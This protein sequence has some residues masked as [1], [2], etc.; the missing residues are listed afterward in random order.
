M[1][2][3]KLTVAL[4][5]LNAK[6]I[7]WLAMESLCHQEMVRGGA[8]RWELIAVEEQ[9]DMMFGE[10]RFRSYSERLEWLGCERMHYIPVDDWISLSKK[11]IKVVQAASYTSMAMVCQAADCYSN[12]RRLRLT[13]G[14]F[15]NKATDWLDSQSGLCYHVPT[16]LTAMYNSGF[17]KAALTS[18]AKYITGCD[19]AVRL[20]LLKNAEPHITSRGN[21]AWLYA[22][23]LKERG[24]GIVRRRLPD[25]YW[26]HGLHTD[27]FEMCSYNRAGAAYA[28]DGETVQQ[29]KCRP[30]WKRGLFKELPLGYRLRDHFSD[31]ILCRLARCS[32]F[33]SVHKN[34]K[35]LGLEHSA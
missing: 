21:D 22:T 2:E 34:L 7:A 23:A 8:L 32:P 15:Y 4:P 16:G 28:L 29:L 1:A 3:I 12:P 17:S 19:P 5:M 26:K 33:C 25:D 31:D 14:A 30:A 10:D 13:Y 6:H 11:Y 35:D 24:K 9:N 18:D 27:G 20:G